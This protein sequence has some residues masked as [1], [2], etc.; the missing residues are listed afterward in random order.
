MRSDTFDPTRLAQ[1]MRRQATLYLQPA[2]LAAGAVLGAMLIISLIVAMLKPENVAGLAGLYQ[3]VFFLAGFVFASQ[4]FGELHSPQQSYA[5]LTLPVSTPEKLVGSWILSSLVY[6]VVYWVAVFLIFALACAVGNGMFSPFEL[7]SNDFLRA[8]GTF[9][10][11]Q[12]VFLL[13]A[14]YFRKFNFLKTVFALFVV[15]VI[16]GGYTGSL[17]WLLLDK[18]SDNKIEEEFPDFMNNVATP[19]LKLFFWYVL[20]PFM[21]IVSYFRLKERQ[22]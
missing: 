9:L 16:V 7:F 1:F 14:C 6:V 22:V 17:A 8:V 13:G 2:L 18:I 4:I 3:A 11:M 21:L 10:V 15:A 5:Y 20:A 12:T 19:A